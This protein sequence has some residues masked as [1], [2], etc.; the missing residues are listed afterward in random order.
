MTKKYNTGN[1]GQGMDAPIQYPTNNETSRPLTRKLSYDRLRSRSRDLDPFNSLTRSDLSRGKSILMNYNLYGG[2]DARD[3]L[4]RI[5]IYGHARGEK[6]QLQQDENRRK[7]GVSGE[8]HQ[9]PR[10]QGRGSQPRL[11]SEPTNARPLWGLRRERGRRLASKKVQPRNG[12]AKESLLIRGL[13]P[14]RR[15]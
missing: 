7:R 14:K 1:A 3:C 13:T 12:G 4:G 11:R 6:Q 8:K 2:G 15:L 9:S 10:I 5:E